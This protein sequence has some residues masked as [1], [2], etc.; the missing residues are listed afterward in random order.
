MVLSRRVFR[1]VRKSLAKPWLEIFRPGGGRGAA[2]ILTQMV[3]LLATGYFVSTDGQQFRWLLGICGYILFFSGVPTIVSRRMFNSGIRTAYVRAGILLFFPI[4]GVSADIF[5]YFL[6]PSRIW[7]FSAYHILNPF[8][9]LANWQ[10]VETQ[11]WLFGPVLMGL[12]GLIT[13][14][15]LYRMGRREDEHAANSL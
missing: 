10:E 9:A 1:R 8:R 6:M 11:G 5:Q 15:E 7:T 12:A 2:W 13:Y 4:V 14:L 3:I